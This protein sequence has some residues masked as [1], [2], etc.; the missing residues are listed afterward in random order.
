VKEYHCHIQL[1]QPEKS[2]W[3]NIKLILGNNNNGYVMYGR[4]WGNNIGMSQYGAQD[5]AKLG[6]SYEQILKF[7]YTGIELQYAG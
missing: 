6:F 1:Y 2:A 7:Y 5:M 4:G 3:W